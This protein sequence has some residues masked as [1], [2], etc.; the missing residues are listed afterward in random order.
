MRVACVL[1]QRN[2]D[3]CLHPWL[4]WHGHLFGYESLYV[5]D[6]GSDDPCV[7]ETLK[8]FGALGVNVHPLPA[9]ADYRPKGE[10]VTGVMRILEHT[11]VYDFLLPL[12]CDEFVTMRNT[13]G[14]PSAAR[15]DILIHLST[16]VGDIFEVQENFLNML[17]HQDHFFALPYQKVFFRSG[18]VHEVDHGSH[19]CIDGT[20]ATPTRLAYA[21]FHH[22]SYARQQRTS[23][24]KLQPYVEITNRA[25]LEA[26]RGVGWH[27]VSHVQKTRAEYMALLTPDDQ[28]ITF[29]ALGEMFELLG[30]DPLFYEEP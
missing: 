28:C 13:Q 23:L 2:E 24:E 21:H 10:Y 30:I 5:L 15:D 7:L 18:S 3:L 22:K 4:A 8:L 16:L 25:A 12:D 11:G 17:G 6:H 26:F 1:M 19:R 27:L 20:P 14:E 9:N 29:P